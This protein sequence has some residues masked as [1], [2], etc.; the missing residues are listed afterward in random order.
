[1]NAK[2]NAHTEEQNRGRFLDS[3]YFKSHLNSLTNVP[4]CP[5]FI[6]ET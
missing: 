5:T 1:M 6:P 4:T 3:F 2:K